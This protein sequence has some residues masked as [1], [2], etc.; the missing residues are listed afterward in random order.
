MSSYSF[1]YSAGQSS[2][3]LTLSSLCRSPNVLSHVPTWLIPGR[4]R[5]K[6]AV[7]IH[8]TQWI[9]TI[10]M[11]E[12]RTFESCNVLLRNLDGVKNNKIGEGIVIGS[13]LFTEKLW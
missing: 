6:M 7:L 4:F 2:V 9:V 3:S 12:V 8:A 13:L 5:H 11:L 1:V 10:F